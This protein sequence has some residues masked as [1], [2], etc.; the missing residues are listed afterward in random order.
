MDTPAAP[1]PAAPV[2]APAPKPATVDNQDGFFMVAAAHSRGCVCEAHD[3][4]VE[5]R[6]WVSHDFNRILNPGTPS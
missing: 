3:Q 6:V 4:H 1:V 2:A 5:K